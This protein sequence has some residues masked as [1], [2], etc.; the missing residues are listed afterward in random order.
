MSTTMS[1]QEIEAKLATLVQQDESFKHNLI[2]NPRLTLEEIGL[3]F[4]P[5][6]IQIIVAESGSEQELSDNELE[7]VSG[8]AEV[9]VGITITIKF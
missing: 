3:G 2:T 9:S 1:K 5:S 7:N 6:D 8:G 4:L